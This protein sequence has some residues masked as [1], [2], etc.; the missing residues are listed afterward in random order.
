M[1]DV[2]CQSCID[3]QELVSLLYDGMILLVFR[4]FGAFHRMQFAFHYFELDASA[5]TNKW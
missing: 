2:I 4:C 1:S 5:S 3:L